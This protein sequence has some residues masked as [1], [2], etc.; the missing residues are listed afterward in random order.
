MPRTTDDL[1]ADWL[2]KSS[3]FSVLNILENIYLYDKVEN[4]SDS[5]FTGQDS[6]D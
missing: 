1:A 6:I 2:P 4:N 3:G 5:N